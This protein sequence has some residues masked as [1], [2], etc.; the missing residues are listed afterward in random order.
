MKQEVGGMGHN[1]CMKQG[2]GRIG[3][4][5]LSLSNLLSMGFSGVYDTTIH[6]EPPFLFI[7]GSGTN[8]SVRQEVGDQ[9]F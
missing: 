3:Q 7:I 8:F 6:N 2:V 4:I 9:K 1:F 5:F